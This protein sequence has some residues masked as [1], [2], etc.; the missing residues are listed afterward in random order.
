LDCVELIEGLGEQHSRVAKKNLNVK[1]KEQM[2]IGQLTWENKQGGEINN[3]I[4]YNN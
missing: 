3:S 2:E 1:N 4:N